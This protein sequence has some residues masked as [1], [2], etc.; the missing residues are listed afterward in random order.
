MGAYV[1]RGRAGGHLWWDL[2]AHRGRWW[3]LLLRDPDRIT[4]RAAAYVAWPARH[5]SPGDA[6]LGYGD[7]HRRGIDRVRRAGRTGPD[8][9][10]VRGVA[11]RQ[12]QRTLDRPGRTQHRLLPAE[13]GRASW[14]ER[15]CQY[16]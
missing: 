12:C 6:H 10:Q 16:V 4:G 1:A 3:E 9:G 11:R 7:G 15:V 8:R 2:H 14:R 5:P 13:L